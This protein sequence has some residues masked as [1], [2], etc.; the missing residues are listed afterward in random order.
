MSICLYLWFGSMNT[1]IFCLRE[2]RQLPQREQFNFSGMQPCLVLLHTLKS[3]HNKRSHDKSDTTSNT[4]EIIYSSPGTI[5]HMH[6]QWNSECI[7]F[8]LFSSMLNWSLWAL[9]FATHWKDQRMISSIRLCSAFLAF[10]GQVFRNCSASDTE[11]HLCTA[12]LQR[13]HF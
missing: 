4:G 11:C 6:K 2:H 10:W 12:T 7:K 8:I 9:S 3:K 5:I 13:V 1:M